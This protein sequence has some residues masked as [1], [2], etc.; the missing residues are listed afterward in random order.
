ME[1]FSSTN[2]LLRVH[3]TES[4]VRLVVHG[5]S[6]DTERDD[7][8]VDETVVL[9]IPYIIQISSFGI[10]VDSEAQNSVSVIKAY[11]L[12]KS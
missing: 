1:A 5:W 11:S 2:D 8:S 9:E 3:S 12:I 4:G 7:S 10:W 6:S